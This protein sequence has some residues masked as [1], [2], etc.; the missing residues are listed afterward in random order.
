M[1]PFSRRAEEVEI[2]SSGLQ[3]MAP[4]ISDETAAII[5]R[6]LRLNPA[7]RQS[8]YRNDW[9][10]RSRPRCCADAG[11]EIARPPELAAE[12]RDVV[13][14]LVVLAV[15]GFGI[16]FG[17]RHCRERWRSFIHAR[18]DHQLGSRPAN[19]DKNGA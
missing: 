13:S 3:T 5:D 15:I 18:R 9:G 12:C 17:V 7:E 4:D 2:E 11:G 16:L 8:S 19:A 1:N 14:V 10:V 6:M